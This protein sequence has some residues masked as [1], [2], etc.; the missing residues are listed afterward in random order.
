M[1]DRKG[2]SG[3]AG[4]WEGTERSRCSRNLNQDMLC[5]KRKESKA[6]P[7]VSLKENKDTKSPITHILALPLIFVSQLIIMRN[8]LS[9]R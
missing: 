1:K 2:G 5:E 3:L 8:K 7:Q 9:Y 4:R 6:K